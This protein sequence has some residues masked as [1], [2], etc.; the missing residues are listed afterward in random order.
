[1]TSTGDRGRHLPSGRLVAT[2]MLLGF[3]PLIILTYSSL[4]L[5]ELAMAREVNAR[6][7]SI[8]ESAST[9]TAG[10]LDS[11][12]VT[13][14]A[15]A[16]DPQLVAA[17]SATRAEGRVDDTEL[18]ATLTELRRSRPEFSAVFLADPAGRTTA[19]LPSAPGVIGKSF[20][21][22]DWFQGAVT[23]QRPHVSEAYETAILDG[24]RVVAVS[25]AVRAGA[26]SGRVLGVAAALYD[27]D[28]LQHVVDEFTRHQGVRITVT[29][30]RGVVLAAPGA[31]RM[32]LVSL[33]TDPRVQAALRGDAGTR[34]VAGVQGTVL[35]A[36]APVPRLGWTVIAEVPERAALAGLQRLRHTVL[37]V[38]ALLAVA[39]AVMLGLSARAENRRR[40]AERQLS[41]RA[42]ALAISERQFRTAFTHAPTGMVRLSDDG[43]ILEANR[44]FHDLLGFPAGVLVGRSLGDLSHQDDASAT[45]RRL[46]GLVGADTDTVRLETRF[47]HADGHAVWTVMSAARLESSDHVPYTLGQIVDISDRK[48]NEARL[49][50]QALHDPLTGL[51]NRLL[52]EERV[53]HALA[54]LIREPQTM[55]LLFIDLDG[56]KT[57]ND[58]FGHKA[59]DEVLREVAARLGFV[60]R[61]GDTVAR[62]GGD[63]FVVLCEGLPDHASEVAAGLASRIQQALRQPFRHGDRDLQLSASIGISR[64]TAT[65]ANATSLIAEA[66]AAMYRAKQEGKA[67]HREFDESMR[68]LASTPSATLDLLDTALVQG[69]LRLQYQPVVDLSTGQVVGAEALLRLVGHDG[70]LIQP[71]DFLPAAEAHGHI[72][73]FGAWALREACRQVAV[74]KAALPADRDFGI[75]VNMSVKEVEDSGLADRVRDVLLE[76]NLAADALVIELTE[77]AFLRDLPSSRATLQRLRQL[78]VRIALDDFGTGYSSLSYLRRMPVDII[79]LDRTFVSDLL[80]DA[81]ESRVTRALIELAHN[82]G[83]VVLA[84]G[85][86]E[87]AQV[88][89]LMEQ[90]CHLAQGY[91]MARPVDPE[92]FRALLDRRLLP[93]EHPRGQPAALAEISSGTVS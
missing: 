67:C 29:D 34:S 44:S 82:I 31:G 68:E 11:L 32:G 85:V 16:D 28:S 35:S 45:G 72:V 66:D 70:E 37:A 33:R 5:S 53:N 8:A 83:T 77:S 86:E 60:V 84:E 90:G 6:V 65:T 47:L 57:V 59:G 30:Q 7:S 2:F 42:A 24:P 27:L 13:V 63:E 52:L 38:A 23:S 46:G 56:F 15:F 89:A 9:N 18:M 55:A 74:W 75:G 25:A 49:S 12:G 61:P 26:G 78:G 69:R 48:V 81:Q 88:A 58:S 64:P 54:R 14:G 87:S 92:H 62:L 22:R 17:M 40:A 41:E 73:E 51:A 91:L 93:P 79:K 1:M 10:L 3:L 50:R 43:L 80:G 4:T 19:V 36:Y 21:Y 76:T 71:A 39:L 20:S